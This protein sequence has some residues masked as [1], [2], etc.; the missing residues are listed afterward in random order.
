VK[1]QVSYRN[2]DT[3]W[4]A[5]AEFQNVAADLAPLKVIDRLYV[6]SAFVDEDG[7]QEKADDSAFRVPVYMSGGSWI[8]TTL[9]VEGRKLTAVEG[10]L[11]TAKAA[12][13]R[14]E[15]EKRRIERESEAEDRRPS[16][17]GNTRLKTGR[18]KSAEAGPGFS[19][20]AVCL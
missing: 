16:S 7:P 8:K 15:E 10:V 11:A 14:Y 12:I 3:G 2:G 20:P 6:G 5:S 19:V 18:F 1:S 9:T 13:N 4:L 17:R